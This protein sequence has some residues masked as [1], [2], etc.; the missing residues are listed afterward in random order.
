MASRSGIDANI[1]NRL[2]ADHQIIFL[3]VKAEFDT[4]TVRLWTGYDDLLINGETY[5]YRDI[6]LFQCF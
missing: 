2:G 3:A 4:D 5:S 6:S 1:T